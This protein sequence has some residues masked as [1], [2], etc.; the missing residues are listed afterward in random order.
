MSLTK[1]ELALVS[2]TDLIK[3][4]ES[5]CICFIAAYDLPE[6]E[7]KFSQ[8]RYSHTGKWMQAC[9]LSSILNN[10][11]LNN[12]GGELEVLRSIVRKS[13]GPG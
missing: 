7:N 1:D 3:E 6:E 13:N 5:R 9:K 8:F 2:L 12:W 10:E 11:V 4:I